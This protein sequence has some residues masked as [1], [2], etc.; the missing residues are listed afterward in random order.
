MPRLTCLV[1]LI[2]IP[3]FLAACT[4]REPGD[5]NPFLGID[6]GWE[7][8]GGGPPP[9]RDAG[10]RRADAGPMVV[11]AG[12]PDGGS[13][14]PDAGGGMPDAGGGMPDAGGGMP[15]AG[16]PVMCPMMDLGGMLGDMVAMGTT[17][18]RPDAVTASC[19]SS[20]GPDLTI[21][22]TAPRDGTFTFSTNDSS[23]DT[24]IS[25]RGGG[26]CS[27]PELACDDD[28]GTGL[29][30]RIDLP[31]TAGDAVLLA[32]EG[33]SGA[34]GDFVLHVWEGVPT[35][36]T[37]CH[38]GMDED[39]DGDTDCLDYDCDTDPGCTEMDCTNGMD[40]DGDGNADCADYDC[41]SDPTCTETNC[42]DGV[43]D[44]GDGDIDC[45]DFDCYSDPSCYEAD[46]SNGVDDDS[47]GDVDCADYD[48]YFTPAC[49]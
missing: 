48:C 43:D 32:I 36:E 2:A 31:L 8:D 13:G 5:R 23:Y 26:M 34:T 20:S 45:D 33:F 1:A 22:W 35:S 37:A 29:D 21:L 11:D 15:D 6:A 24:V 3:T 10:V 46:C 38:D 40:D 19:G 17:T 28:G 7:A 49:P 30:S 4:S 14:M 12:K 39:R 27:G 41:D 18:G 44:E 16:P 47:D 9:M 25:A 42:S